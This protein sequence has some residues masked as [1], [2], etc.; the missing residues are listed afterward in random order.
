MTET[1]V[2]QVEQFRMRKPAVGQQVVWYP[3]AD[4]NELPQIAFALE[5]G[6]RALV[7]QVAGTAIDGV[8]HLT[9]PKLKMNDHQRLNGAWDFPE[10]EKDM[11]MLKH[12]TEQFEAKVGE[13]LVKIDGL[14][15]KIAEL[16]D[17]ITSGKKKG[18]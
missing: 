15:T 11:A 13:L 6:A 7:L 10:S 5:V 9:D 3:H 2:A 4:V 14:T 16:E 1:E 18:S 8:R 17:L 12:R